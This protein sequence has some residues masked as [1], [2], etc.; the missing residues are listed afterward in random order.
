MKEIPD[1]LREGLPSASGI[2]RLAACAGSQQAEA[3]LPDIAPE[4]W[5]QEGS[6]VHDAVHTGDDSEL[7]LSEKEIAAKLKS[8]EDETFEQWMAGVIRISGEQPA[9]EDINSIRETRLWIRDERLDPIAS[10]QPDSI[11][12]W[13]AYALCLDFKTGYKKTESIERNWQMRTQALAVKSEYPQ[14]THIRVAIVASRLSSMVDLCDYNANYLLFAKRDLIQ[15]LWK[16]KQPDAPRVP[17]AHCRYCKAMLHGR[18]REAI[19]YAMVSSSGLPATANNLDVIQRVGQMTTSELAFVRTRKSLA[20]QIFE[21]V[22]ARLKT[23]SAEELASVGLQLAPG[24]NQTVMRDVAMAFRNLTTGDS[25]IVTPKELLSMMKI[26]IGQVVE[27]V[28]VTSDIPKKKAKEIVEA[29]L[30]EAI[31]KKEGNRRLKDL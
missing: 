25:P 22:D 7:E 20:E 24:I 14:V 16:S 11:Y 13:G 21:A 12:L 19:T 8:L 1:S 17:G 29:R 31:E 23:L 18:C 15:I 4:T 26:T 10:A 6:N 2:S 3:G 5:T 27:H 28:A 30:G 9:H